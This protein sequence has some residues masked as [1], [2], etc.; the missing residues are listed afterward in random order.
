MS[1]ESN[2]GEQALL[3]ADALSMGSSCRFEGGFR[4]PSR[5]RGFESR[6]KQN[7]QIS[8]QVLI[9]SIVRHVKAH[10]CCE[11][12]TAAH[13]EIKHKGIK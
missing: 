3:Q 4:P 9:S 11:K 6:Q 10:V 8:S 12:S 5:G 13:R 1:R 7:F 2:L